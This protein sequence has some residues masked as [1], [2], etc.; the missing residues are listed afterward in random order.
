MRRFLCCVLAAL[1]IVLSAGCGSGPAQQ[2]PAE[3]A[4]VTEPAA[5]AETPVVTEPAQT[6]PVFTGTPY[7]KA[8]G[9]MLSIVGETDDLYVGVVPR[10]EVTFES[11][12]ETVVTFEGGVLTAVG[13]GETTVRAIYGDK[14]VECKAGCLAADEAE[15]KTLGKEVLRSPKR[16]P[17]VI[18][19]ENPCT[20]FTD[21]VIIG[22][23]ITLFMFQ[24]EQ[25]YDYLGEVQYLTRGGVSL[26][27]FVL[28]F[29]NVFYRGQEMYLE[30]AIAATG[31]K[32]VY[33]MMGQNDLASKA[34]GKIMDNWNILL[35]RIREK[36]P[37]VEIYFQSCI[38]EFQEDYEVDDKNP[39]IF[40][41]N[42]QLREFAR[43]NG[44][45]FID[46]RYYI[47][48]HQGRMPQCYSQGNY[49]MNE[50]GCYVWMQMLRFYAQLEKEGGILQ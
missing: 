5:K 12:D 28:R 2:T 34:R 14:T 35:E 42:D 36:A 19:M 22:D 31:A 29:K 37:D 9:V 39:R 40:A 50:Q 32:K 30:D 11:D 25:K 16:L 26:N 21:A 44:D 38:P 17:P 18:D 15:L 45:H 49:H 10:E 23:S 48:D 46:L 4:A 47:E 43:E 24:W 20:D 8:S 7:L 6:E 3:T 41:Y 1:M 27:G 13:V 33:I